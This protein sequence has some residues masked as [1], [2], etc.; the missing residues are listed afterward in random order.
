MAKPS[1]DLAGRTF[2]L[3]T[4]PWRIR[5]LKVIAATRGQ[6]MGAF[7]EA[8]IDAACLEENVFTADVEVASAARRASQGR[9]S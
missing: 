7:L 9:V 4:E 6:T 2:Q 5:A 1:I 3:I 8:A